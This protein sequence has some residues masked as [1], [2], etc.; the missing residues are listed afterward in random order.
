MTLHAIDDID[1]AIDA[2]K[3]FLFPFDLRTWLRLAFVVF[4]I[5]GGGGGLNVLRSANSFSNA[6]GGSVPTGPG[7]GTGGEFALTG[8]LEHLLGSLPTPLSQVSGGSGGP[9]LPP[10]VT[11]GLLA[12]A[13]LALIAALVVILLLALLFGIV[14][15]FMEFVLVQSLVDREVHVRQYFTDNLGNGLRLLGFRLALSIVTALLGLAAFLGFFVVVSGGQLA[16][17]GPEALIASSGLLIVG[18]LLFALVLG[19]ITGF[20]TVFVVPLM[21]QGDHGVLEGWRR[22]L[23]SI[24]DQPKQYLAYLFFSVILGI[25]VGIVG[26]VLGG[27][28]AVVL[29]IPFGILAAAVWFGLGQSLVAGVLASV[30]LALF[31]LALLVV[32]NLIKVPLL[33]FLRYYAMLVLGDIDPDMDPIPTVRDD[34][35]T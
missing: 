8:P 35:R 10:G 30:F 6:D 34:I 11:E 23:G 31:A 21:I 27:V 4:F 25:G 9:G 12:G 2:T 26:A 3:A 24:S 7:T 29:L 15:N 13:G 22:L 28:A 32:A 16:N 1:D 20:T 14:S 33:T 19:T 17:L 5:G 18:A